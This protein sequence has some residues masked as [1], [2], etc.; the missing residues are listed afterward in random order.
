MIKFSDHSKHFYAYDATGKKLRAEYHTPIMVVTEPQVPDM[1]E[2]MPE[3]EEVLMEEQQEWNEEEWGG[4]MGAQKKRITIKYL[5]LFMLLGFVC[6]SNAQSITPCLEIDSLQTEYHVYDYISFHFNNNCDE[7]IYISISLEK[8]V[9]GRWQ[10]FAQDIF[11]IPS[12]H[13]VENIII[14][15]GN[16]IDRRENW[17]IR[18]MMYKNGCDNV[19]RFKYNICKIPYKLFYTEYSNI[20][21]INK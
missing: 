20:F 1:G 11:Q 8:K 21:Y 14:L 18:K 9:N 17:K 13:K 2:E 12:V 16:E 6:N 5:M 7:K 10:L 19:Y 4:Q 3:Q 15:K